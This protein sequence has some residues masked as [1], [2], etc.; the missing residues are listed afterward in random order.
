MEKLTP[1][2]S[3]RIIAVL[4][5]T[6]EKLG[7]LGSI[8]PDVLQHRDELSKFVGDEIS[9]IIEEQRT[10][11]ARY[12]DLITQRSALKG[13]AN[14][15]RYKEVQGEIQDVSRA[16][17]E[18]TKN[19]CRNL[20][21]NPNV[22]GNLL[23]IQRERAELI[24]LIART[25]RELGESGKFDGVAWVVEEDRLSQNKKSELVRREKEATTAVSNLENDLV[26]ER[27]EDARQLETYR[28]TMGDLKDKVVQ[29]KSRTN[30]DVK[31]SR[32]EKSAQ[33]SS[34]QRVNQQTERSLELQV[35]E[36]EIRREKELS[37]HSETMAFLERKRGQLLEDLDAWEDRFEKEHGELQ[38]QYETLAAE[39]GQMLVRLEQ[40]KT[41][42]ALELE[43]E[44]A[45]ERAKNTQIANEKAAKALIARQRAAAYKIQRLFVLH[46]K[47]LKEKG[48]KEKGKKEKKKKKG[49][50]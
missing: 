41:R 30:V 46:S 32:K 7:F 42:R 29:M 40:L 33:L 11:E 3:H 19:L 39:R 2:Q 16:L 25:S 45:R 34:L 50:K 47:R 20:K 8:T 18:S 44:A 27:A 49:K 21:N 31:Y 43:T 1:E 9:R 10:L 23:K 6:I 12:E 5:D 37:A 4:E 26:N 13:L 38:R 35:Q 36:L 28:R 22:S 24:D 14:K 17:R 15:N 48:T